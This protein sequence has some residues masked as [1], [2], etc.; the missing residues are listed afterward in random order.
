[1]WYKLSKIMRRFFAKTAYVHGVL[2]ARLKPYNEALLY[3]IGNQVSGGVRC[4]LVIYNSCIGLQTFLWWLF[5]SDWEVLMKYK[6]DICRRC[7]YATSKT[8]QETVDISL[9]Q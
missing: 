6:K 4:D 8:F 5:L 7:S 2:V 1:M 3:F 9:Y